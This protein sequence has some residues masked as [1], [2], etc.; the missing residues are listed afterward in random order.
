M[1]SGRGNTDSFYAP[2][3]STLTEEMKHQVSRQAHL[4][5]FDRK[6]QTNSSRERTKGVMTN[7]INE[8]LV[9]LFNH[10]DKVQCLV[11]AYLKNQFKLFCS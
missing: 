8:G 11:V 1:F 7:L 5:T 10:A 4:T 9:L 6:S 2:L 3:Q